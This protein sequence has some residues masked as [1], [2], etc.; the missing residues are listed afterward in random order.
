MENEGLNI[1]IR[2]N[3]CDA[4]FSEETSFC[5]ECGNAIE[6]LSKKGENLQIK[7]LSVH[8]VMPKYR[9]N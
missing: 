2:C 3:N 8:N 9:P 7:M 4:E 6:N 5:T 1:T